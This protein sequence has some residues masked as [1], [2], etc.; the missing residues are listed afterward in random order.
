[1]ALGGASNGG[2][3]TAAVALEQANLFKIVFPAVGVLDLLR[4]QLFTLGYSWYSDYGYSSNQEE[5]NNL[6]QF[7]PLQNIK[8]QSYP[9]MLIQT[10]MEDG[11][12]PPLHSY[13]LAATMQ[14]A[15][16]GFSPYLLKS[17][18]EQ[19]HFA[20]N[21]IAAQIDAWTFFF[22]ETNTPLQ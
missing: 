22:N 15:A 17:Y 5:F 2:L 6:I 18:P 21:S 13:K 1:M 14:N 9:A 12:V 16:S 8:A 19:G 20:A 7:S 11:R 10:G 4:Y 3:T